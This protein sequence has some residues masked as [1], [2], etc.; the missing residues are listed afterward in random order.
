M[1]MQEK[2]LEQLTGHLEK[3]FGSLGCILARFRGE[4]TLGVP[5]EHLLVVAEKLKEMNVFRFEQ[6]MD[7]CGVDYLTYGRAE[8]ETASAS[9]GGFGRG[10]APIIHGQKADRLPR[11]A[12]VYH[13]LSIT[14]NQRL[15]I[16]VFISSDPPV[17]SSLVNIWNS[18]NW[19]EREAFDLYGILFEGHPDLRRILT[20]YGFVGHPFRKDFPLS[21]YVEMRYDSDKR[22]VVYEPVTIEAR[23]LVPKVIRQDNRYLAGAAS[24]PV[25]HGTSNA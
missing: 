16:K 24:A 13:L 4:L 8:W 11:Y 23:V 1:R 21:G 20:D 19:F 5:C 12:A 18:A 14:H 2:T 15:R 6:L 17:V 25:R 3:H 22:R 9:S 7:V 10:V